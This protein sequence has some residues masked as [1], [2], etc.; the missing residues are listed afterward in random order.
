MPQIQSQLAEDEF[1]VMPPFV[2]GDE[3]ASVGYLREDD[4][5]ELIATFNNL[6]QHMESDTFYAYVLAATK[7]LAKLMPDVD[8]VALNRE[9]APDV[10][11][12]ETIS[13]P[14]GDDSSPPPPP[15]PAPMLPAVPDVDD[16]PCSAVGAPPRRPR[17]PKM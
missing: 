11:T 4:D 10:V 12:L 16:A 2:A 5:F 8:L 3:T 1:L 17:R 15:P 6:G 13:D 7:A 14:G 9:D